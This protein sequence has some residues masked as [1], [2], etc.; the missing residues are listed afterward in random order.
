MT[1]LNIALAECDDRDWDTLVAFMHAF[2]EED[3]HAH[4][5]DNEAA[6]RTLV[7]TPAH[8][9]A[10][11]IRRDDVPIGYAALCYGFSLEFC[12]RDGFLDEIYVVPGQ[13]GLG[14]GAMILDWLQAIAAAD[15][16]KALHLEVMDG[17]EQAASL[18]RRKGWEQ[19][20]SRMMTKLLTDAR[21]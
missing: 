3:G 5:P 20:P 17:N 2:C 15:G 10:M 16:L 19:R 18:Y 21:A 13:R 1:D 4:G 8:G 6:L 12:G 9:R 11:L 14:I 7:D